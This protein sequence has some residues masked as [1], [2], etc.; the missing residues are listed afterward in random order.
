MDSLVIVS[1]FSTHLLSRANV[2][3]ERVTDSV[4]KAMDLTHHQ[5]LQTKRFPF[6]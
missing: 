3:G 5:L 1:H 2:V 4:N 6:E